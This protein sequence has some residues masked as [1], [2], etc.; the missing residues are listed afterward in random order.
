MN[1]SSNFSMRIE[2]VGP[3]ETTSN[4][5]FSSS[6]TRM[7]GPAWR[8][9]PSLMSTGSSRPYSMRRRWATSRQVVMWPS[10]KM[11]SPTLMSSMSSRLM[12]VVRVM[13]RPVAAS[14]AASASRFSASVASR[15]SVLVAVAVSVM[16]LVLVLSEAVQW[17]CRRRRGA[18]L[19]PGALARG[20]QAAQ[21]AQ[22]STPL[23]VRSS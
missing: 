9:A 21:W 16:G 23:W 11:T 12:G 20:A 7:I 10:R 3:T 4:S 22:S 17:W 1:S 2:V 13:V 19:G 15:A 14:A 6:T 18:A 5:S 8:M